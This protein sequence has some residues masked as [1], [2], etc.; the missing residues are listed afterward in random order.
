MRS[1]LLPGVIPLARSTKNWPRLTLHRLG[2]LGGR[3]STAKLRNG[4]RVTLRPKLLDWY[5]F[6]EAFMTRV[7]APAIEH[8]CEMRGPVAMLDLGA[9]LGYVSLLAAATCPDCRVRSFEPGPP[10]L[11]L[12]GHHLAENP[13][14]APRIEVQGV[15]VGGRDARVEWTFDETNPGGSS[16]FG[17]GG[18]KYPVQVRSFEGIVS[19]TTLPIA[20]VKMDIEGSEYDVV[21]ETPASV[22]ERVGALVIEPH[23]DPSGQSDPTRLLDKL[24]GLGFSL[25]AIHSNLYFGINAN[26]R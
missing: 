25:R 2:M 9:N 17:S 5:V 6:N 21:K 8:L 10:H 4:L 16:L 24:E 7:Y 23:D 15:A 13:G 26:A 14:V 18:T 22:W 3:S 1:L 19:E 12:I 11:R 20:L